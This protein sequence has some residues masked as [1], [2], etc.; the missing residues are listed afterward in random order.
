[1]AKTF[2]VVQG[3]V[4]A[5]GT[6]DLTKSGFG[7]PK[8]AIILFSTA[9][10]KAT[11]KAEVNY[12]IGFTDGTSHVCGA[13]AC[14]P[15][16]GSQETRS[17]WA[18]RNDR[19]GQLATNGSAWG[20][21]KSIT[22]NSWITDGIRLEVS[23]GS[24]TGFYVTV[25][26]IGGTGNI[27]VGNQ[28]MNAQD[29]ATNYTGASFEPTAM[30]GLYT[31]RD[32]NTVSSGTGSD[33]IHLGAY[34]GT[35]QGGCGWWSID[36]QWIPTAGTKTSEIMSAT[37]IAGTTNANI[38][39]TSF[40]SDGWT[41]YARDGN[42][43]DFG[44]ILLDD[45]T[46]DVGNSLYVTSGNEDYTGASA[47]PVASIEL[48][49]LFES[50]DAL[51]TVIDTD[52][53][54]AFCIGVG[55]GTTDVSLLCKDEDGST[56]ASDPAM[57]LDDGTT[58][59]RIGDD[60]AESKGAFNSWLSNGRRLTMSDYPSVGRRYTIFAF[61]QEASDFVTFVQ[62]DRMMQGDL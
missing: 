43:A 25:L 45:C 13:A 21:K 31:A 35:D 42:P 4:P 62:A 40:N 7:T 32:I 52:N 49:T 17:V 53:S 3:T 57:W 29:V 48:G 41:A 14:F 37:R 34:N 44:F 5:S 54:E 15:R 30:I 26:L 60:T 46:L 36:G 18:Y 6:F 51:Q 56:T 28:N 10:S 38:E 59:L 9:T 22:F 50:T 27:K 2:A 39:M 8:G 55:D 23:V 47:Q 33:Y 20:D 24:D 16:S 19:V 12:S 1:M 11:K 58:E 61:V